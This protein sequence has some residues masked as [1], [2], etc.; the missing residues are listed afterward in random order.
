MSDTLSTAIKPETLTQRQTDLTHQL[1]LQAAL[2][3]LERSSV[4]DLTVRRVAAQANISER[5]IF[6]Y[7]STRDE[8]L[9]AIAN[10]VSRRM[11]LPPYPSTPEEVL[12]AP[13]ALY[14][15][16]EGNAKLTKAALHSELFDRIRTAEAHRRWVAIRKVLD[17][18]AAKCPEHRRR[19]AA[20]NI[21]FFL[22]AT[23]WHYYRFYFGF[24]LEETVECGRTAIRQTLE[25]ILGKPL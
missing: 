14:S 13:A 9:D 23:A 7:F 8:F 4:A 18:F 20:A 15:C 22:S 11:Q 6:R 1:I 19:L 24:T 21:R 17:R 12:E 10:E 5:T 2:Q 25:G 16:F 3:L